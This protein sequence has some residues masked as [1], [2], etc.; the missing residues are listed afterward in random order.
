[1]TDDQLKHHYRGWS[2]DALISWKIDV[3]R[4]DLAKKEIE[5][6]DRELKRRKEAGEVA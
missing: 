4:F 2:D 3:I 1:M 5:W 6:I